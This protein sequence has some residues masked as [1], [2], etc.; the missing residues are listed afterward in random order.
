MYAEQY[1]FH[2]LQ[3]ENMEIRN[4]VSEIKWNYCPSTILFCKQKLVY[5]L[6]YVDWLLSYDVSLSSN[7]IRFLRE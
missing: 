3:T 5:N 2:F 7:Q 4:Q 1:H 6:Y